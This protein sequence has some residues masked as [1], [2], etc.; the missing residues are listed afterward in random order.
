MSVININSSVSRM[1]PELWL[2][3]LHHY[4]PSDA[5]TT[6]AIQSSKAELRPH[7]L[8]YRWTLWAA[9]QVSR[10]V[11][12]SATLCLYQAVLINDLRE[13]LYFY[14]T[15]RTV[16]KLQTL[17]RSFSWTGLLPQSDAEDTECVDLMPSLV[18]VFTSLPPPVTEK[19]TLLH[20]YLH[21]DNL[22]EFR[23]WQLLGVVLAIIPKLT[24]LFLV[25]GR[26]MP[27]LRIQPRLLYYEFG[28]REST[29][30]ER[31][32]LFKFRQEAYEFFAIRLLDP[33]L[34]SAGYPFLPELQILI[35]DHISNV[36]PIAFNNDGVIE[37]LQRLCPQLR[38]IQTK[39]RIHLANAVEEPACSTSMKSLL[40]RN[41]RFP[42]SDFPRMQV[43]YPNLISLRIVLL[44]GHE[45]HPLFDSFKA[46]TKLRHLQYLSMTT[47]HDITWA[48]LDRH[49]TMSPFLHQMESLQHL[50]VD[51]IWLTPRNNPSRL[52][53]I[54]SLLPPSI[55]SLHLLDYWA[56]AMTSTDRDKYPVFPDDMPALEF[57]HLMLENLLRSCTSMGLINLKEVKL[58]SI[59]YAK[60]RMLTIARASLSSLIRQFWQAGICLT[61]TGLEEA[62]NEEEGWWL[63]LD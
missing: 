34:A 55:K 21:G 39:S 43:I 19:D 31:A 33:V 30:E 1:S 3:I 35:L 42:A 36:P 29:A 44:S 24:T 41:Q 4:V 32:D 14:R 50:R 27:G 57:L 2:K 23:A 18:P 5:P 6:I 9:C 20:Q 15:L 56:I 48:F 58:S 37:D 47:P 10:Q 40:V 49:P 60:G 16:P 62:R 28:D 12:A 61:M 26:L 63:N 54:A 46:L 22:A 25:L 7:I 13:L 17:V 53:H 11:G 38:Y 8:E 45:T 59:Q 51:F 52:L